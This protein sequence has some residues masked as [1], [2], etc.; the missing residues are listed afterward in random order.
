MPR[1]KPHDRNRMRASRTQRA[2]YVGRTWQP[3]KLLALARKTFDYQWSLEES[4]N[5]VFTVR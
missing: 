1:K 4:G 2:V 3:D 5:S